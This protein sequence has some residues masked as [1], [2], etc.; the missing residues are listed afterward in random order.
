LCC[1]SPFFGD[2]SIVSSLPPGKGSVID[3]SRR[4]SIL[5][6]PKKVIIVYVSYFI[7]ASAQDCNKLTG[8]AIQ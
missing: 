6:T 2:R 8:M 7:E 3:R 4:K 1:T 5:P